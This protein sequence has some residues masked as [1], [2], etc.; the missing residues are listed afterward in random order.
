MR[1]RREAEGCGFL[2]DVPFCSVI[3]A[4]VTDS[5]VRTDGNPGSA[6]SDLKATEA[7]AQQLGTGRMTVTNER[8]FV[9]CM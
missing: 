6:V 8:G 3:L 2:F 5:Y 1:V 9:L 4:T 7:Q